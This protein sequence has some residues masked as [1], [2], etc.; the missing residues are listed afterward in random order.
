MKSHTPIALELIRLAAPI[1]MLNLAVSLLGATDTLFMGRISTQAVAAVGLGGLVYLTAYLLLRGTVNGIV[2]FVAQAYGANDL[3]QCGKHLRDFLWL[4]LGLSVFAPV[5]ALVFA[6]V[7][8]LTG[9][10]PAVYE[11]ALEFARIRTLEIP[12]ALASTA[13]LGFLVAQG[14][15]RT[16]MLVT[17]LQVILNVG[18]NAVLV[19][20]L[21]GLP[22]LGLRGSAIGT[23][24][25][26]MI[27][28]VVSGWIV[29][30]RLN[31]PRFGLHFAPPDPGNLSQ[32]LR[33]AGP[34]GLMDFVEVA[35][36]TAFLGVIA[37]IG[38]T[39]LAASQIANQVSS[40]AFMPGFGLS[41]AAASMVGRFIGARELPSA[42]HTG[43]IGAA[44]G[45]GWMGV[46]GVGFWVFSEPLMRA[47]TQD[48]QVI[49]LGSSLLKLMAVWQVFDAANIVFRGALA[50]AGD[51]RFTAL[52]TLAL[53]WTL[54]VAG[55]YVLAFPVGWGLLGAWGGPFAYLMLLAF[56]YTWRWRSGIWNAGIR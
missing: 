23:V 21:F 40:L 10:E 13:F 27:G 44:I 31:R 15:S 12:F 39:E 22:A 42:S 28:A 47:F 56:I 49:Q 45:M 8:R 37:R 17:W 34:L 9:A 48:Q 4:A 14:N 26:V 19:F 53:A 32:I 55:G 7:I 16:P 18:L 41:T 33:V 30:S 43:Y 24:I 54:M 29:L 2:T 6:P 38:T 35:A 20:G 25:A 1:V 36:F 51:T 3:A 5:F 52:V 50:G 11:G 46:V